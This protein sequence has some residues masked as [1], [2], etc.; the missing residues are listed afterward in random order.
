[1][2]GL[3]LFQDR[4]RQARF[5]NCRERRSHSGGPFAWSLVRF[6]DFLNARFSR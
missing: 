2:A 3:L 5:G 6:P 1:M 4:H